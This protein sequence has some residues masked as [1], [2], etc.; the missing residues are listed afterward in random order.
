MSSPR[1]CAVITSDDQELAAT[2]SLFDL[3]EVRIDLIGRG[4]RRLVKD[5]GKPW[6]ACNRMAS[7]GGAWRGSEKQRIDELLDAVALGA[8]VVDIELESEDLAEAV[9]LIKGKAQCLVSFHDFAGTPPL[10]RMQE[11]VRR[12]LEAG[13][14]ICKVVTA[15]RT[16]ADNL[17]VLQLITDFPKARL[18]SFAMGDTG[19]VSRILCPLVGGDFTYASMETGRESAAGQITVVELRRIYGM[20]ADGR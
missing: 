5:L 18:V 4:W 14:D 11:I 8:G 17:S 15:A 13:A 19:V 10:D 7:E 12:Q 6:I 20:V 16:F 9:R 3:Y 2:A 1:I